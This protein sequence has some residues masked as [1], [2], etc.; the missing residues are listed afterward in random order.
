MG[1]AS[2]CRACRRLS[3]EGVCEAFPDGIPTRIL[4]Q[5][6]DHRLPFPGDRGLRFKLD[7]AQRDTLFAYEAVDRLL[8]ELTASA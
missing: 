4:F 5:H 7:P 2:I 3:A 1:P 6:F 8:R